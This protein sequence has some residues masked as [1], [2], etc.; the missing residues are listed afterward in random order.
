M[1][2]GEAL[3]LCLSGDLLVSPDVLADVEGEAWPVILDG[4]RRKASYEEIL[5]A[6][7]EVI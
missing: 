5:A 6:V 7:G 3:L 1:S 4:V 2:R